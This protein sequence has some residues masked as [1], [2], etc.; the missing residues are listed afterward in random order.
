MH[1][2]PK[3]PFFGPPP[4]GFRKIIF[5]LVQGDEKESFSESFFVRKKEL[6]PTH[7]RR[8]SHASSDIILFSFSPPLSFP[9]PI[10]GKIGG[11]RWRK[12]F[13]KSTYLPFISPEC[14]FFLLLYSKNRIFERKYFKSST[15][16]KILNLI[17][18]FFA[19]KARP[20]KE[21]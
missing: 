11:G 13:E 3:N 19:R 14:L 4:E 21:I 1:I 12:K 8:V 9:R 15:S 16:P 7:K 18:L 2:L 17:A 6:S 10:S 20:P 5:S